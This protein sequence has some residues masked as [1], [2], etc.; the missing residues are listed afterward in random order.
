LAGAW[1]ERPET[2]P[3]LRRVGHDLHVG[4]DELEKFTD[5]GRIEL[6]TG[7]AGVDKQGE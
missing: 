4:A 6:C 7:S 2:P 1:W 5:L 3:A